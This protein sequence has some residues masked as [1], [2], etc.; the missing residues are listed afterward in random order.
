MY[1]RVCIGEN[2][3][4]TLLHSSWEMGHVNLIFSPDLAGDVN[5]IMKQFLSPCMF[6]N[7]IIK[8]DVRGQILVL[9]PHLRNVYMGVKRRYKH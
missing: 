2:A 3:I 6:R 5:Q 1:G 4:S 8:N 9:A 7:P